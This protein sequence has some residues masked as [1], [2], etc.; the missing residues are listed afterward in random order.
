MLRA[1]NLL[2][3]AAVLL[4][5]SSPLIAAEITSAAS[6]STTTS[7]PAPVS[8]TVSCE[9][10]RHT[11]FWAVDI[12]NYELPWY[13]DPPFSQH[14]IRDK[15]KLPYEAVA[16]AAAYVGCALLLGGSLLTV[17]KKMRNN[18]LSSNGTLEIEMVKSPKKGIFEPSPVSPA[19]SSR[20][21]IKK[22]KTFAPG[23]GQGSIRSGK[24]GGTSNPNSPGVA[25]LNSFN[26][27]VM[28]NDKDSRQA[29]MERLYA[30]V[31]THDA[32]KESGVSVQEMEYGESTAV[33]ASPKPKMRVNVEGA[34]Q[35]SGGSQPQSPRSPIKAIYPPDHWTQA[36]QLAGSQQQK[37]VTP[38]TPVSP[39]VQQVQETDM[40]PP[41]P[42]PKSPPLMS[43]PSNG[44]Q[45]YYQSSPPSSPKKI[46]S[47]HR[48]QG[49]QGSSMS[50]GSSGLNKNRKSIRDMR[51][52]RPVP[53]D[54]NDVEERQP[55]TPRQYDNPGAPPPIPGE[56]PD[57]DDSS[58]PK[59]THTQNSEDYAAE[60][61]DEP[62]PLPVA[63]PQRKPSNLSIPSS[64]G[65]SNGNGV[66]GGKSAGSS[67]SSLPFRS[68]GYS[69]SDNGLTSPPPT[70][71]TY[72]ESRRDPHRGPLTGRTPRTGVPMTPYSPY[73]P[74][75]PL[76]PVT[77]RLVTRADRKAMK[78]DTGKKVKTEGDLVK[79]EDE[80]WGSGY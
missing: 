70:K 50:I 72:I 13:C 16:V 75:T 22:L 57:R 15:S 5:L 3:T 25:S 12:E 37:P 64:N 21:W 80:E 53:V 6:A 30:A 32:A 2:S 73:M 74:F 79:D 9:R 51:I 42:P 59:T 4:L 65:N 28:Q 20:S 48:R 62:K 40:Y 45:Q 43:H 27:R 54:P 19:S 44:Q 58:T 38:I 34:R 46:Q 24:T 78:K 71:T 68:L 41:S 77:P 61:L 67:S 36:Q 76:T 7:T 31:M 23:G 1:G 55:L 69:T 60:A 29:E 39:I 11:G 66:N 8:S 14:A 52:S 18:A 26:E 35:A 33:P 49:S 47:V 10:Y 17:G 63:Q 56:V